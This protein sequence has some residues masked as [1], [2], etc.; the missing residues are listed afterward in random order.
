MIKLTQ[1]LNVARELDYY[2]H[3]YILQVDGMAEDNDRSQKRE[4]GN[5][6]D[7]LF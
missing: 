6:K 7:V 4:H 1:L 3:Y 2:Y 5:Q